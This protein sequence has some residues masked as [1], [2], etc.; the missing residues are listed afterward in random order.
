DVGGAEV[1]RRRVEAD[2]GVGDEHVDGAEALLHLID[3]GLER[4]AVGDVADGGGERR[5]RQLGGKDGERLGVEIDGGDGGALGGE[6]EGELPA[7]PAAGAGDQD[8]LVGERGHEP[9]RIGRDSFTPCKTPLPSPRI[10]SP[11]QTSAGR[12][13]GAAASAPPPECAAG[14]PCRT[15]A[16]PTGRSR[17]TAAASG[18]APARA[19]AP[20]SGCTAA[21]T[22][23]APAPSCSDRRST[24]SPRPGRPAS[25][26]G[27]RSRRGRGTGARA[28]CCGPACSGTGPAAAPPRPTTPARRRSTAA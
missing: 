9:L 10:P 14:T 16:A 23:A 19:V 22:P 4:E 21:P 24:S 5:L 1:E 8:D 20:A 25:P 28:A 3:R 15:P 12:R 27:R 7:D 26:S 2:A 6:G 11:S 17:P 13:T 18:S